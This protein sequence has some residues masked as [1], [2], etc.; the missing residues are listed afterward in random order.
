MWKY[1][2]AWICGKNYLD[3]SRTAFTHCIWHC[4]TR[5][6]NHGDEAKETELICGEV[7]FITVKGISSGKLR[8]RKCW[9]AEACKRRWVNEGIVHKLIFCVFF[10]QFYCIDFNRNWIILRSQSQ[11]LVPIAL[12][13]QVSA[14]TEQGAFQKLFLKFS[15]AMK[16]MLC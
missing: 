7:H 1:S 14:L 16:H 6:I 5:W 11:F 9:V 8:R 3:T 2:G 15:V 4:S 10:K 12:S 13:V